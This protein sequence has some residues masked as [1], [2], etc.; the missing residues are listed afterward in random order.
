VYGHVYKTSSR[1][2]C[3]CSFETKKLSHFSPAPQQNVAAQLEVVAAEEA[4]LEA[5][6]Q[7]VLD[8]S[9]LFFNEQLSKSKEELER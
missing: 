7:V 1:T 8:R 5:Q 2:V 4:S 9:K 6:V 3:W